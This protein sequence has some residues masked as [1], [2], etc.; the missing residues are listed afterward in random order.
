V[1]HL[2][3]APEPSAAHSRSLAVHSCPPLAPRVSS[4]RVASLTMVDLWVEL[5]CRHSD[6]DSCITIERQRDRRRYQGHNLDGDFDTVDTT[7]MR[8]VARTPMAHVGSGGGWMVLA[9]HLY[10]VVWPRKF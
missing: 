7:P 5:E 4:V 3:R 6:E 10:K 2:S 1:N 8:Q 9:P